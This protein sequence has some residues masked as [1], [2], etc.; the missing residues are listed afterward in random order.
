LFS[1]GFSKLER[2]ATVP[3]QAEIDAQLDALLTKPRSQTIDGM[4]VVQQSVQDL[5]ALDKHANRKTGH[6]FGFSMRPLKPPE[7]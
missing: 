2:G 6:R 3:T 7:H 4:S 5:I 1:R